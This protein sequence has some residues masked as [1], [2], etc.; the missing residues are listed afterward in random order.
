M[1]HL[2]KWRNKGLSFVKRTGWLVLIFVDPVRQFHAYYVHVVFQAIILVH[3]MFI[4]KP[5]PVANN[6]VDP[7]WKWFKIKCLRF[8]Y[9][10]RTL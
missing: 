4:S 10:N 8:T 9:M 2:L 6:N 5:T 1:D 3:T 7:M